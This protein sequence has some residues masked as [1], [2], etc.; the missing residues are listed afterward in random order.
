VHARLGDVKEALKFA[1]DLKNYAG[2][3]AK[4]DVDALV[5]GL[6]YRMENDLKIDEG[7]SI[8]SRYYFTR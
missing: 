3:E 1:I 2:G 6:K 8:R 4:K 7:F 5:E